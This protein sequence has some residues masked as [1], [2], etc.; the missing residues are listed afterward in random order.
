MSLKRMISKWRATRPAN[1]S[2]TREYLRAKLF[3]GDEAGVLT[4]PVSE[5][6]DGLTATVDLWESDHCCRCDSRREVE[7]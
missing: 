6:L 4:I 1:H 7:P 2:I 3:D 5:F